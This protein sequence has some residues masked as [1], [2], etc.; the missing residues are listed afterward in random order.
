[1]PVLNS[2]GSTRTHQNHLD[3][4]LDLREEFSPLR[5][6]FREYGEK[7][8]NSR[9]LG[10]QR[11]ARQ[12]IIEV[13][14]R[15]ARLYD[16]PDLRGIQASLSYLEKGIAVGAKPTDLTSYSAEL[17]L[18]PIELI[19]EGW[20]RRRAIHLFRLKKK[21]DHLEDYGYLIQKV[22]GRSLSAAE[23]KEYTRVSQRLEELLYPSDNVGASVGF[24][25][26]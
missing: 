26:L 20:I 3:G 13:T 5:S 15:L 25:Q 18:K 8:R 22:F 2:N 14:Q 11:K 9:T 19:R 24:V 23:V 17:L 21:L 10:D 6:R 7:I 4:V 16:A 1:M 12:E